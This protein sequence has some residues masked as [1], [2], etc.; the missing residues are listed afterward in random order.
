[1]YKRAIS[2]LILI[3]ALF[4][5]PLDVMGASNESLRLQD[6]NKINSLKESLSAHQK[7]LSELK[8]IT[9]R[10]AATDKEIDKLEKAI[11]REKELIE[12][13]RISDDN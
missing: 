12:T 6:T 10:D 9:N 7:K 3:L 13:L 2:I 1:M 11:D 4:V 8:A 5:A